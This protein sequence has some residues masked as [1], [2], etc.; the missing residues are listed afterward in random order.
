MRPVQIE[1]RRCFG[2]ND[3]VIY[4]I[5]SAA[6]RARK[7]GRSLVCRYD[8]PSSEPV[9]LHEVKERLQDGLWVSPKG[10]VY[11]VDSAGHVH[12]NRA[13]TWTK[14]RVSRFKL[15][16]VWGIDDNFVLAGGEGGATGI[17]EF[18]GMKWTSVK[19]TDGLDNLEPSAQVLQFAGSSRTDYYVV[20]T[21]PFERPR[22]C[23]LL[24][25]DGARWTP[26][27]MR[28]IAGRKVRQVAK[29]GIRSAV[30]TVYCRDHDEVVVCGAEGLLMSGS[31]R[32]GWTSI[33]TLTR[34]QKAYGLGVIGDDLY[35]AWRHNSQRAAGVMKW[36]GT[37]ME[38]VREDIWPWSLASSNERL[39]VTWSKGFG[40]FDGRRWEIRGTPDIV[41]PR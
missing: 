25:L 41:R 26:M 34:D 15:N 37:R 32:S 2:G 1:Y 29:T 5:E 27:E 12:T 10:T 31:P 9:V 30:N 20:A 28:T 40:V 33:G 22:K 8:S 6:G 3:G 17:F 38:V 14:T 24:H 11:T 39:F 13:G 4:T 19:T 36:D 18:D 35:F 21:N 23:S 7:G 16:A